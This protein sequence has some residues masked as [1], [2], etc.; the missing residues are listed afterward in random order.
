MTVNVRAILLRSVALSALPYIGSQ[1]PAVSSQIPTDK[2]L[3]AVSVV[4]IVVII[5]NHARNQGWEFTIFL[6]RS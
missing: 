3:L 5:I 2:M 1:Q 6:T 4:I